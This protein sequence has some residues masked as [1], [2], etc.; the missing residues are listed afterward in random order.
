[1]NPFFCYIG[2]KKSI[3]DE[4][5][6]KIPPHT[7]YVEPFFGGGSIYFRK[8][9]SKVEIINDLDKELMEA[10]V[11]LF[12]VDTDLKKYDFQNTIPKIQEFV[13]K[14]HKTKENQFLSYLY[15]KMNSFSCKGTGKIEKNQNGKNKIK[16]LMKYQERM[17][18]TTLHSSD[19]KKLIKKYDS[20]DTFFYLD[21]PYE[22]S[23]K[24][25]KNDNI[26]FK[27]LVKILK[28]IKGKF[29]LSI[30]ESDNIKYLFRDFQINKISV[31][32]NSNSSIGLKQRKELLISN[33]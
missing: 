1:M 27:D 15:K 31:N 17:K 32:S 18:N 30:N 7:T 11:L 25:Y 8:K 12:K 24:L 16:S 29:I 13:N 23:D 14:K 20:S 2:S 21:P 28:K 33:F 22:N 5:I 19:Y 9:P 6:G 3:A 10:Y 4:I 26:D